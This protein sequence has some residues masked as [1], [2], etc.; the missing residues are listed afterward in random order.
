MRQILPS[1]RRSISTT[2][3]DWWSVYTQNLVVWKIDWRNENVDHHHLDLPSL[4]FGRCWLLLGSFLQNESCW[5][6]FLSLAQWL[7]V[8]ISLFIGS[9]NSV[10]TAAGLWLSGLSGW[11]SSQ[12]ASCYSFSLKSSHSQVTEW[13]NPNEE[14]VILGR[15]WSSCSLE[16]TVV[17]G[18]YLWMGN[19]GRLSS[20][21]GWGDD[22]LRK[23]V[24]SLFSIRDG[25]RPKSR[26][27]FGVSSC[28]SMHIFNGW[29]SAPCFKMW[30]DTLLLLRRSKPSFDEIVSWGTTS[31]SK[32][33]T[34]EESKAIGLLVSNKLIFSQITYTIVLIPSSMRYDV[35]S[36]ANERSRKHSS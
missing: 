21:V 26:V 22:Y 35:P 16:V 36:L 3:P 17:P 8:F 14:E 19:L 12:F 23:K 34:N 25:P 4:R 18:R 31:R 11:R 7:T 30:E 9:V 33:A 10:C 24:T 20:A 5:A 32:D 13:M 2:Q 29:T 6:A 27:A 15:S 1:V 28:L